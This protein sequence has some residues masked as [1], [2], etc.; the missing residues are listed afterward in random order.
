[1]STKFSRLILKLCGAVAVIFDGDRSAIITIVLANQ[2]V[3][4]GSQV[5]AVG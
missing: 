2:P 3:D 1:M 5:G 4:L